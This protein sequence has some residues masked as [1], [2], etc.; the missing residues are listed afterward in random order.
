MIPSDL[1]GELPYLLLATIVIVVGVATVVFSAF[2]VRDRALLYFGLFAGMYGVRLLMLNGIF[3]AAFEIAPNVSEWSAAVISYTILVPGAALVRILI[4]PEWRN[5]AAW[6]LRT[7]IVFAP[8]AIA[9]AVIAR[10]PWAPGRANNVIVITSTLLGAGLV[11]Y[12]LH[13]RGREWLILCFLLFVA[14]V[15]IRNLQIDMG[16]YNPEPLGF[17]VLLIALGFLAAGRALE[18]ERRLKS[19][20]Y[21]L[22]MARRIQNSILPQRVPRIKG[23]V[24]TARYEPMKEVAGDF[25]D[26]IA[27]DERRLTILVADVSGHG[28]PAAL[29][30]S[31]LKVAFGAQREI[32]TDPAE[33][34]SRI[35]ATLHGILDRQF[36]TAACAHIDLEERTV[37][38]AGA[39]HPPSLLWKGGTGELVELAEGERPDPGTRAT[40]DAGPLVRECVEVPVRDDV[41]E[42]DRVLFAA[43]DHLTV[44]TGSAP[45]EGNVDVE[46]PDDVSAFRV[47]VP[48]EPRGRRSLRRLLAGSFVG[49]ACS[50]PGTLRER[51]RRHDCNREAS[52]AKEPGLH[53]VTVF[54][55]GSQRCTP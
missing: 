34:L 31:M 6:V 43:G 45:G 7:A 32:A 12:R 33:L 30:A 55:P 46:I 22:E 27:V 48:G 52:R 26:F 28:V 36:V 51:R 3:R 40:G 54:P 37:H 10:N 29:I 17:L 13:W 25:Y 18:R 49:G 14:T 53:R 4:G 41:R 23:L 19:V 8:L 24:L 44:A 20:E 15:V 11:V 47:E 1:R 16:R 5:A 9:W 21:E 39:G 2:K 38:Y 42:V 50:D 35:N